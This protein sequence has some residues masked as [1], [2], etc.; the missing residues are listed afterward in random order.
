MLSLQDLDKNARPL[1]GVKANPSAIFEWALACMSEAPTEAPNPRKHPATFLQLIL[2]AAAGEEDIRTWAK[3][4]TLKDPAYTTTKQG[5]GAVVFEMAVVKAGGKL[6]EHFVE[7]IIGTTEVFQ[8]VFLGKLREEDLEKLE[9]TLD[10]RVTYKAILEYG[11]IDPKSQT[12]NEFTVFDCTPKDVKRDT[13]KQSGDFQGFP[14]NAKEYNGVVE[15]G[16]VPKST[17]MRIHAFTTVES[18]PLALVDGHGVKWLP[19]G[20]H[21]MPVDHAAVLREDFA[22]AVHGTPANKASIGATLGKWR[23]LGIKRLPMSEFDASFKSNFYASDDRKKIDT[24]K[25]QLAESHA[26]TPLIA[27]KDKE[28][29]YILEGAHRM[30]ALFELGAKDLPALVVEDL[31][32]SGERSRHGITVRQEAVQHGPESLT[33]ALVTIGEAQY[34]VPVRSSEIMR[35]ATRAALV[36]FVELHG[37][38]VARVA[39]KLEEAD[40]VAGEEETDDRMDDPLFYRDD[41]QAYYDALCLLGLDSEECEKRTKAKFSLKKLIVTPTG[42]VRSPGVEDRPASQS[43]PPG[44]GAPF[45][46]A[47]EEPAPGAEEPAPAAEEPPAEEPAAKTA[48]SKNSVKVVK[49]NLEKLDEETAADRL[50]RMLDIIKKGATVTFSTALNHWQIDQKTVDKFEKAGMPVLKV[51]KDDHIY[52]A[53]GRKYVDTNGCVIKAYAPEG[54]E[55]HKKKESIDEALSDDAAKEALTGGK[56]VLIDD[57]WWEIASRDLATDKVILVQSEYAIR[58]G[59]PKQGAKSMAFS[60]LVSNISSGKWSANIGGT[61]HGPKQDPAVRDKH[62]KA[63]GLPA[64]PGAAEIRNKDEAVMEAAPV[65]T[66]KSSTV[67]DALAKAGLDGN[68]RFKSVGAGLN[69]LAKVLDPF[70]LQQADVNSA[71]LFKAKSGSRL[72]NLE[73]VNPKDP[74]SPVEVKEGGISFSWHEVD[75]DKYEITTYA[76]ANFKKP[77]MEASSTANALNQATTSKI[78]RSVSKDAPPKLSAED[79]KKIEDAEGPKENAENGMAWVVLWA[80]GRA[81]AAFDKRS[82]M[83]A[84]AEHL[85]EMAEIVSVKY[86]APVF[87]NKTV[88]VGLAE[89]LNESLRTRYTC[90]KCQSTDVSMREAH[91]DTGMDCIELRCKKCGF[92][93]DLDENKFSEEEYEDPNWTSPLDRLMAGEPIMSIL[94]PEAVDETPPATVLKLC[95]SADKG[96]EEAAKVW[97]HAT[98]AADAKFETGSDEWWAY[99]MGVVKKACNLD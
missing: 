55:L 72:L 85:G 63:K 70:G 59:F 66:L 60:T 92:R 16:G 52:M 18:E 58:D 94:M 51:G 64:A 76:T 46:G 5:L 9:R 53:Q 26:V 14:A 31:D 91:A 73:W 13:T 1:K 81:V 68:G 30:V 36:E 67:S 33:M 44:A 38:L 79:R 7:T 2:E 37:S 83:L 49:E 48:T 20:A 23:E 98:D 4:Y 65:A 32:E 45:A 29:Y 34:S 86:S 87:R 71:D 11:A 47:A 54:S 96:P 41:V 61:W 3:R 89:S 99:A 77:M 17:L 84:W 62:R 97:K 12:I 57:C 56:A 21:Y 75:K 69:A 19:Q 95:K 24:L 8:A 80:D 43:L 10:G 40:D 39:K 27:V 25:T 28:G 50:A 74:H 6:P 90:P 22:Y 88:K 42:E 82:K 35:H 78:V 15:S 93:A